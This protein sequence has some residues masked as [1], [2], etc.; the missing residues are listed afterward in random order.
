MKDLRRTH[1]F[2]SYKEMCAALEL[3]IKRGE[4]KAKQLEDLGKL[5]NVTKK[6]NGWFVITKINRAMRSEEKKNKKIASGQMVTIDGAQVDLRGRGKY[7]D[8]GIYDYVYFKTFSEG[9]SGAEF[10][11][12]KFSRECFKGMVYYRKRYCFD[13]RADLDSDFKK[14]VKIIGDSMISD[15]VTE[16]T[17]SILKSLAKSK[18][19]DL[20]LEDCYVMSD[21]SRVWGDKAIEIG[22]LYSNCIKKFNKENNDNPYSIQQNKWQM[23]EA[24]KEA[25]FHSSGQ[26]KIYPAWHCYYMSHKRPDSEPTPSPEENMKI[27]CK[28]FGVF[29]ETLKLKVK[30]MRATAFGDPR[31]EMLKLEEKKPLIEYFH[32]NIQLDPNLHSCVEDIGLKISTQPTLPDFIPLNSVHYTAEGSKYRPLL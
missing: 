29:R 12:E 23:Q 1:T 8:T 3:P 15:Q 28:F 21:D 7:K 31:G 5:Y 13:D 17:R 24:V 11:V 16:I 27:L 10:T 22:R 6:K 2:K 4:E 14:R 30:K 26:N 25:Y 18:D 9:F 19:Y 32:K 20:Q